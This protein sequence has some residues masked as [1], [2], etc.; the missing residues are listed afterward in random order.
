MSLSPY[1]VVILVGFLPNETFRVAAVF[2]SRGFDERSEIFVWIRCVATTLLAAVV[3]KLVVSPSAALATLPV[4]VSVAGLAAGVLAHFLA[5][6]SLLT[7]I[8]AGEAVV[9][10]CATLLDAS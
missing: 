5:R 6:R 7:G 9:I 10:G 2:L 8:L 3:A 4:W 1:L